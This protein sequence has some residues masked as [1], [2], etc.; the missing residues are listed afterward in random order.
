M[1]VA[2]P[3]SRAT[4]DTLVKTSD[5]GLAGA[6]PAMAFVIS[7]PEMPRAFALARTGPSRIWALAGPAAASSP[8]TTP[9]VATDRLMMLLNV[10]FPFLGSGWLWVT[11]GTP[12][13]ADGFP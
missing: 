13:A 7:S 4:F 6:L 1:V 8:A 3:W 12:K 10:T 9:R 5:V 2:S 11:S